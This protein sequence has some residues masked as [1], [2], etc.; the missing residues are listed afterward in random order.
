[1]RRS[2]SKSPQGSKLKSR[3]RSRSPKA[4]NPV[5]DLALVDAKD[6]KD[7]K[8]RNDH[9]DHKDHKSTLTATVE[10]V[11]AEATQ[12]NNGLL[13]FPARIQLDK[14]SSEPEI[15][16][17][18]MGPTYKEPLGVYWASSVDGEVAFQRRI[19]S[20]EELVKNLKQ[21]GQ[22][23]KIS[24]VGK[25]TVG[26]CK[27]YRIPWGLVFMNQYTEW[28]YA[29]EGGLYDR[30]IKDMPVVPTF[31]YGQREAQ[32]FGETTSTFSV[33]DG[34]YAFLNSGYLT[35]TVFKIDLLKKHCEDSTTS[36]SLMVTEFDE[37]IND[38][39]LH[40]LAPSRIHN[41]E[42]QDNYFRHISEYNVECFDFA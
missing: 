21:V 41:L 29:P 8:D 10:S 39:N 11:A 2:R 5:L 35:P 33:L 22:H 9:N 13:T 3:S 23:K 32:D 26:E 7:R 17:G 30:L 1:M 18:Y 6:Q 27:A 36:V 38:A 40:K 42:I 34:T 19:N 31:Y 37:F 25:M 24:K 16:S 28:F 15:L 12:S 4:L 20:V 14:K